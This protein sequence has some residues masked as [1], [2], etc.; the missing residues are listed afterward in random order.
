LES[1]LV[2]AF[3]AASKKKTEGQKKVTYKKFGNPSRESRDTRV[4]VTDFMSDGVVDTFEPSTWRIR[5]FEMLAIETDLTR[6]ARITLEV[7]THEWS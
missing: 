4:L 1:Q 5:S 2:V 6:G 7:S 3:I